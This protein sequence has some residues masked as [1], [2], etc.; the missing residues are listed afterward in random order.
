MSR[1]VPAR[2]RAPVQ[3]TMPGGFAIRFDIRVALCVVGVKSIACQKSALQHQLCKQSPRGLRIRCVDT[4]MSERGKAAYGYGSTRA[5]RGKTP[6]SLN[7]PARFHQARRHAAGA[8]LTYCGERRRWADALGP[9]GAADEAVL[10]SLH[11]APRSN[12]RGHRI[13]VRN[14][15]GKNRDV[16]GYAVQEMRAAAVQSPP[17]SN[18]VKNEN[19][20]QPESNIANLLE[21]AAIGRIGFR[22]GSITTAA[23]SP[24]C[25]LAMRS[26]SSTRL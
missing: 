16:G 5:L 26:S 2:W 19:R 7:L 11:H 13:S 8:M 1:T 17:G 15:F 6:D 3:R 10:G 22:T 21:K 4:E 14:G 12:D 20:A 25:S 23:S 18:L 24:P 9:V